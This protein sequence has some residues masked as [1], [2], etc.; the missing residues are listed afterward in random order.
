VIGVELLTLD[1]RIV[2]GS[3]DAY[4]RWAEAV[5]RLDLKRTELAGLE[6]L[7][8]GAQTN[9]APNPNDASRR[10]RP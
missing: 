7:R 2:I 10:G 4:L 5:N 3:L 6:E 8:A 9:D 1:T